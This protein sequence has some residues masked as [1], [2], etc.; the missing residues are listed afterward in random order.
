MALLKKDNRLIASTPASNINHW[1]EE[2]NENIDDFEIEL[3]AS[4]K[5][6][7]I[8]YKIKEKVGDI[9][10]IV[11]TIADS[12]QLLLH[13]FAQLLTDLSE[14]KTIEQIRTKTKPLEKQFSNF[15]KNVENGDTKLSYK[16]K[17]ID[18]V[19]KDFEQRST[20]ITSIIEPT[21][22]AKGK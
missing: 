20:L 5:K 2:N 12:N 4:E 13:Q 7:I 14:A 6:H 17:G 21:Q 1:L 22:N 11:G 10:S 19:I 18:H 8:R 9:D 15:L 16:T 3:S